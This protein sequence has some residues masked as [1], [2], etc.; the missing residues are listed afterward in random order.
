ML[1][2]N[3]AALKMFGYTKAQLLALSVHDLV[4]DEVGAKLPD[5]IELHREQGMLQMTSLGKRK[6]GSVFPT[7]V[8][9]RVTEIG[10]EQV[11][12]V[13][14]RDVTE[15]QLAETA[16]KESEG[17]YRSLFER[18]PIGLFR[19]MPDGQVLEVNQALVQILGY[20]D[21]DDLLR[22]EVK[23]L[24]KD[25]ETRQ[26]WRG[27]IE[28]EGVAREF[29]TQLRRRDGEIIWAK[30][31]A[32]VVRNSA[33]RVLCYEGS[34]EDITEHKRVDEERAR[35]ATAIE[36]AVECILVTDTA[37]VVQY[38]NPAFETITGYSRYE[39]VGTSPRILK[40]GE[41]SEVFYREL[42]ETISSG[43]VWRGRFFNRRKDGSQYEEEATVSPLRDASGTIT[44]YVKVSR[45]VTQEAEL[46]AQLRQSQKMEAVGQLA[47]GVAHD[48]NNL[49]LAIQGHGELA[50]RKLDEDSPA[51]GNINQVI[52][53]SRRAA[54]LTRQLLA[55]SR[56]QVLKPIDLDFNEIIAELMK[57]LHRLIGEHIE[58]E[59][60]PG[61]SLGN[62]H[63]D[64]GQ[65]EQVL[66]NLVVNA[67]DAMS[68]GGKLT[69]QVENTSIDSTYCAIHPWAKPGRYIV[70]SVTDT[71]CGMSREELDR[72]FEPFFTTKEAGVGT[73]LGLSTVYGIVKQHDG[74]VHVYSEP[75]KGT[76]VKVY[77]PVV[78]RHASGAQERDDGPPPGGTETILVAEDEDMVRDLA[79]SLLEQAGYTVFAARD[80]ADAVRVFE[81]HADA[82]DLAFLDVIMPKM[83]GRDVCESI[84]S[85][86]PETRFLFSSGYNVRGVHTHFVLDQGIELVEKPY[87]A[88]RL[89]REI[90]RVLDS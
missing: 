56:R 20:S 5:I 37:G 25:R 64:P 58:L 88:N 60:V 19:A 65:M 16:A 76:T 27:L 61:R 47:G 10:G 69:V 82:I 17:R 40:S 14:V 84:R 44:G 34:I 2:C 79:T 78:D 31:S 77:L 86:K 32:R 28:R 8:S 13:F 52:K 42:W 18:V 67:R 83:N 54:D 87:D 48:F 45:D 23:D 22:C 26:R 50:L 41:Q 80:G 3:A 49:L 43:E 15:R 46:Q 24:F 57:M 63:A 4:P 66:M 7:E 89:L 81:Q 90:R 33:G 36:Q 70:L 59:I 74:L 35:L 85:Q 71:G 12:V 29:E 30:G 6:S 68:D 38:V 9:T 11:A 73:G 72:V 39:V 55:F 51:C 21:R 75:G 62:V 1:D 53:A